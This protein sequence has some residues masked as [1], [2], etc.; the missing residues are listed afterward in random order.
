MLVKSFNLRAGGDV[1]QY[2]LLMQDS[3]NRTDQAVVTTGITSI[4]IAISTIDVD[5]S[6][7]G[8]DA[9]KYE[10]LEIGHLYTVIAS[11]TV[12]VDAPLGCAAD[13]EVV[14]AT[15]GQ[16]YYFIACQ[17]GVANQVM[18]ARYVGYQTVA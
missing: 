2:A 1:S 9:L 5:V 12:A 8:G 10:K 6:V 14:T 13:G 11:T 18:Q 16:A 7:D 17:A 3:S 4:P 15:S